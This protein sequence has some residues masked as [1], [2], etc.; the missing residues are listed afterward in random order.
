MTEANVQHSQKFIQWVG[1]YL[2]TGACLI[3]L[4]L[5]SIGLSSSSYAIRQ[6]DM[7]GGALP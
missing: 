1:I 4:G 7:Q 6:S 3:L 5:V 2:E